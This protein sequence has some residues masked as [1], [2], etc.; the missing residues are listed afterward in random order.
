MNIFKSKSL[1]CII[2]ITLSFPLIELAFSFI[3]STATP[4]PFLAKAFIAILT[5]IATICWYQTHV[6]R[7][8][9]Q[10]AQQLHKAEGDSIDFSVR[11]DLNRV[12]KDYIP[13]FNLINQRLSHTESTIHK[14][15]LSISRL[16]PMSKELAE[17]YSS[18]NQN[19]T[20][21]AHHG[22]IL[23]SSINDM[24]VATENIEHD[25]KHIN[26]NISEMSVD[27]K[28]FDTHLSD[29]IH[30]IDTIEQ[31]IADS[32]TVLSDLRD[33]SNKIT[34]IIEEITSIAEQTNLLA[35]NAAIEAARAGEQ[36]RGFAVVADEVRS[37][38]ERTRGSA[39]E[40]KGI[41]D[42]I[43]S[44]TH[45]VSEVMKSSQD[46]IKTTVSSAQSSQEDL[47]KTEAAIEDIRQLASKIM[48]SMHQQS[49]TE[50]NS[51]NSVD[52]L[53]ELNSEALQQV[54]IQSI[55]DD[56][57]NKLADSIESKLKKLHIENVKNSHDRRYKTRQSAESVTKNDTTLF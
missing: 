11:L 16:I 24:L 33:D 35:L 44:G 48:L 34:K 25:I 12:T 50:A 42:S 49:E 29:T 30:S 56:D 43:Y 38:A 57:L 40:V 31:H 45:N 23:S 7:P 37:L 10:C 20:M 22:N 3:S 32:N 21:Q 8:I 39:D 53:I 13:L 15:H 2:A 51:K 28:D 1:L 14:L 19:T 47:R 5:L 26:E 4:L 46:D 41:V 55:T 6:I 17:T 27:I 18:M 36:G 9:T 52:A 54:S